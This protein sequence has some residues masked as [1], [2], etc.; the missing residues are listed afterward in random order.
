LETT[1]PPIKPVGGVAVPCLVLEK[2]RVQFTEFTTE[3]VL[4]KVLSIPCRQV[5]MDSTGDAWAVPIKDGGVVT[6]LCF[7]PKAYDGQGNDYTVNPP[8]YDSKTCFRV[9]DKITEE[10]EWY[11]Y[12]SRS[13][14]AN[15]CYTCCPGQNP[16]YVN[17]PGVASDGTRS[18]VWRVAP[19]ITLGDIIVSGNYVSYWGL[20]TL[21]AGMNYF[22]FGSF[23]NIP[24]PDASATGYADTTTLL[25]WLNSNAHSVGS[26]ATPVLTWSVI[27]N[28]SGGILVATGGAAGD[29]VGMSVIPVS[30]T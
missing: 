15:S 2:N 9:W 3:Y 24:F 7:I 4:G 28:N 12:G 16:G 22:P 11:I 8:S 27:P 13:D 14:F 30:S 26:P 21:A 20:P 5:D 10:L 1:L 17:M 19:T 18:L 23:N 6:G 25:A 29:V